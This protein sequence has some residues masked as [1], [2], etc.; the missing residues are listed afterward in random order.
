MD[1]Y[2]PICGSRYEKDDKYCCNCGASRVTNSTVD[3]KVAYTQNEG[4][5]SSAYGNS[6]PYRDGY[7]GFGGGTVINSGTYRNDT[8]YNMYV[9]DEDCSGKVASILGFIFAMLGFFQSFSLIGFPS[10]IMGIIFSALSL[11]KGRKGAI[12]AF[13]ITSFI[14]IGFSFLI[15]FVVL[16][17]MIINSMEAYN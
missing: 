16:F 13:P 5:G 17:F 15:S 10:M 12:K 7:V 8:G 9:P 11:S 6:N 1:N 3:D 14:L 4:I 2:C